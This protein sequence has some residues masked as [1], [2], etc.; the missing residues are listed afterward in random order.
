MM[1]G[2][3]LIRYRKGV[4]DE[5]QCEQLGVYPPFFCRHVI[6]LLRQA[7]TLHFAVL[8]VKQSACSDSHPDIYST[9]LRF[10]NDRMMVLVEPAGST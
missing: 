6:L 2:T 3:C 9:A 1:P 4:S 10:R 8:S 5:Q 7:L